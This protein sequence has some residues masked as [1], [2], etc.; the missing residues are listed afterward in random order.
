MHISCD[1][2][3]FDLDGVLV[4]SNP[5]SERHWKKWAARHGVAWEKI[6]HIHHGRPTAQ[7]IH[8]VAPQLDAEKQADEKE[9]AEADDVD[10]LRAFPG[11][12][13]LI[14]SLPGWQWAI[15]TSGRRRTATFRLQY[16]GLP[17]PQVFITADDISRG[18][19]DPE[20]YRL[21]IEELRLR[22]EECVVVE[23]APA[24]IESARA[25]G[26]KTIGV[27]S[28]NSRDDLSAADVIVPRLANLSVVVEN[29]RL[30]LTCDLPHSGG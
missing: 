6:A 19:P 9:S 11:A 16:L 10:G 21:A 4:D 23:D 18:K 27:L 30:L 29:G 5:I 26:A 2:L 24:G 28:T 8:L 25:A 13:E 22:P 12:A 20:P 14:R 1:A 3:I 15:V 17:E 7:V